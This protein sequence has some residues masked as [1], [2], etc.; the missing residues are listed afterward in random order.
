MKWWMQLQNWVGLRQWSDYNNINLSFFIEDEK[1]YKIS[2]LRCN[3]TGKFYSKIYPFELLSVR[4]IDHFQRLAGL[5]EETL[6]EQKDDLK[7]RNEDYIERIVAWQTA[8]VKHKK[9]AK[10][11]RN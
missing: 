6:V 11:A 9:E 4:D 7:K 2:V 3:K 8:V 10:E 5:D 1:V